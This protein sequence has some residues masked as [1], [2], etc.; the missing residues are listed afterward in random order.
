MD[1]RVWRKEGHVS[2]VFDRILPK[3]VDDE[4]RVLALEPA[5]DR[6]WAFL[7]PPKPIWRFKEFVVVSRSIVGIGDRPLGNMAA[8]ASGLKAAFKAIVWKGDAFTGVASSSV[9]IALLTEGALTRLFKGPNG[10]NNLE[11]A[12][13]QLKRT[14]K[15]NGRLF[16]IADEFDEEA[17]GGTG[18]LDL[19]SEPRLLK[20]VGFQINYSLR[21][22][23]LVVG[24][25]VKATAKSIRTAKPLTPDEVIEAE[26][27]DL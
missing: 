14:L 1:P 26:S 16:F 3:K 23:G 21:Q 7:N 15:P 5:D 20:K 6:Y 10:R 4:C 9:D 27:K 22:F 25:M 11:L 12:L 24:Y 18:S 13:V 19:G 2:E 17:F 8:T